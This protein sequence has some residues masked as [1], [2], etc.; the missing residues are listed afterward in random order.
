MWVNE[1]ARE[2]PWDMLDSMNTMTEETIAH[3]EPKKKDNS[4]EIKAAKEKADAEA[5]K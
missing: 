4:A 5:E 3:Y 2:N 1:G